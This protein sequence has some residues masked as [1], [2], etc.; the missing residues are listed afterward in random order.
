MEAGNELALRV[1][2]AGNRHSMLGLLF[3][4]DTDRRHMRIARVRYR[5]NVNDREEVESEDAI[6]GFVEFSLR[7]WFTRLIGKLSKNYISGHGPLAFQLG[8]SKDRLDPG[9]H[10]DEYLR[11]TPR[12]VDVGGSRYTYLSVRRVSK[13]DFDR[14]GARLVIFLVE[15]LAWL[16]PEVFVEGIGGGDNESIKPRS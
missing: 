9:A 12:D 1:V 4:E 14:L 11:R 10:G 8:C 13:H 2:L 5:P 3:H 15:N 16:Q 7:E 6:A